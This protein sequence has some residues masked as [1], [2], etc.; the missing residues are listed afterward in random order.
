MD[1]INS[2][3][4]VVYAVPQLT[5]TGIRSSAIWPPLGTA[6]IHVAQLKRSVDRRS[7]H[8]EVEIKARAFRTIRRALQSSFLGSCAASIG[9]VRVVPH[10]PDEDSDPH[11]ASRSSLPFAPIARVA[12]SQL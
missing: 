4:A 7:L 12:E 6:L 8:P 11:P 10:R 5:N 9:Q 2:S 1:E 3:C